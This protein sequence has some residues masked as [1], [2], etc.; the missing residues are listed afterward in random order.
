[1]AFFTPRQYES[2]YRS[3]LRGGL[4]DM[5]P[6]AVRKLVEGAVAYARGFGFAPHPDYYK[7]CPIFGDIDAAACTEQFEFGKDGK[8]FFIAGPNETPER[9]R[10]IMQI[11]ERSCGPGGS[12][13]LIPM[14]PNDP[15]L[16]DAFAKKRAELEAAAEDAG[17]HEPGPQSE[18]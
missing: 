2:D 1:M 12:T 10:R 17:G 5:T 15:A 7:A 4:R 13:F 6:A 9:C 16:R 11:L 18:T 14:D 8:P 3:K